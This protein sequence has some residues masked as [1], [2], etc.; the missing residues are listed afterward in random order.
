MNDWLDAYA[1]GN[2][3]FTMRGSDGEPIYYLTRWEN[4]VHFTF[5]YLTPAGTNLPSL[6]VDFDITAANI[7]DV[8]KRYGVDPKSDFIEGFEV[9]SNSGKG[10][11]FNKAVTDGLIPIE[12]SHYW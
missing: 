4:K 7:P 5:Q 3:E 9:I 1:Q 8:F 11:E 10:D 12:N 6:E 2:S